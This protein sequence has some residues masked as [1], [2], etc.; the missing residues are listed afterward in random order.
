MVEVILATRTD[1]ELVPAAELLPELADAVTG[2]T[3]SSGRT[4]TAP[5]P[6]SPPTCVA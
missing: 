1:V 3:S 6:C 5:T 4:G 2:G